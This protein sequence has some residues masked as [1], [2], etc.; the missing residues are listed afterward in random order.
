MTRERD[1]AEQSASAAPLEPGEQAAPPD[2]TAAAPEPPP[3]TEPPQQRAPA[4]ADSR[5]DPAGERSGDQR[6]RPPRDDG[7]S[8]G[9]GSRDGGSRDGGSRDGGRRG[10]FRPRG[11]E[12][13]IGK[14]NVLDY[15]DLD[16]LRRYIGD[17]AKMEPRRKVG[18][19][20]KHQRMVAQAVERARYIAL[21]PYTAEHIRQTGTRVGGRR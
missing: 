18:T 8:R 5:P 2:P 20:A 6:D 13:C 14:I 7:E 16:R 19:C 11:C 10:G 15:K 9:R 3:A 4:A 1:Q 17:R 12:F 21:L